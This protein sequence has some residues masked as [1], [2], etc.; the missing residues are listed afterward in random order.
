MENTEGGAEARPV[1][2]RAVPTH[3]SPWKALMKLMKRPL[4]E[5]PKLAVEYPDAVKLGPVVL[6]NNPAFVR[7][8][9]VEAGDN[10][11]KK[12]RGMSVIRKAFGENLLT[13]TDHT[14]WKN[15]R[16]LE[17]ACFQARAIRDSYPA[18]ERAIAEL[19]VKWRASSDGG[20]DLAADMTGLMLAINFSTLLGTSVNDHGGEHFLKAA[21]KVHEYLERQ[22]SA[23]VVTP[24]LFSAGRALRTVRATVRKIIAMY[25]AGRSQPS[26]TLLELLIQSSKGAANGEKFVG[27]V[28]DEILVHLMPAYEASA[29]LLTFFWYE[30]AR[31]PAV[32]L[33]IENELNA[34][35]RGEAPTAEGIGRLSY[36]SCAVE[37]VLRLYPPVMLSRRALTDDAIGGYR[38]PAGAE[39]LMSPYAMHRNPRYWDDPECFQ[40]ERH[41]DSGGRNRGLL[42]PFGTGKRV[43]MGNQMTRFQ[44]KAAIAL[45]MQRCRFDL[46]EAFRMEQV[47]RVVIKSRNGLPVTVYWRN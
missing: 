31:N 14:R 24:P 22:M 44:M 3:R 4:D 17:S 2:S 30:I 34:E 18:V 46:S 33:K 6:A 35:F 28:C 20:T 45:I 15:N 26:D 1:V 23:L 10:F 8:V 29:S 42:I 40:P 12:N 19:L 41:L 27:N 5:L 39:V 21:T 13:T 43:C 32:R 11:V 37:E 7:H 36:L 16:R 25:E 38:I 47:V 9:L